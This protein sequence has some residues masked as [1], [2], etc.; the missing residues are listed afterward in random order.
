MELSQLERLPIDSCDARRTIAL[1][2]KGG[3]EFSGDTT[4]VEEESVDEYDP[5]PGVG[6]AFIEDL[7]FF[8][9]V[10]LG[11]LPFGR[12]PGSMGVG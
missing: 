3:D 5:V 1:P 9:I 10:P 12:C 4:E 7:L 11:P 6:L 2:F 8:V